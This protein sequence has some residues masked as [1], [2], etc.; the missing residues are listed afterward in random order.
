MNCEG[1]TLAVDGNGSVL[2]LYLFVADG[3]GVPPGTVPK[4]C[5]HVKDLVWELYNNNI[6]GTIPPKVGN[7]TNL[8]KTTWALSNIVS[9]EDVIV[10]CKYWRY[11]RKQIIPI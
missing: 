4:T 1:E 11:I 5:K 9:A 3:S 8:Y 10:S 6:S 7:L 2:D